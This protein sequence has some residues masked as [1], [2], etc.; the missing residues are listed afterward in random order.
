LN[1][2][3]NN[4]VIEVRA[5]AALADL[6]RHLS[7]FTTCVGLLVYDNAQEIDCRA[8]LTALPVPCA[9]IA[10][11][12]SVRLRLHRR[13]AVELSL[14]R[15]HACPCRVFGDPVRARLWLEQRL[16]Q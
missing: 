15:Y 4:P 8:L 14:S 3:H 5:G 16:C 11:V 7:V 9:G 12:T 2:I 6:K 1:T 10:F 13:L